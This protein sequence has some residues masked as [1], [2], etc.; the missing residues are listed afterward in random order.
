MELVVLVID[1][2]LASAAVLRIGII[3]VEYVVIGARLCPK[4]IGFGRMDMGIV[5]G[6]RRQHIVVVRGVGRLLADV[7]PAPVDRGHGSSA[8][9]AVDER[10]G[11]VLENLLL[12]TTK[13][14]RRLR[15]IFVFQGDHEDRLDRA[16]IV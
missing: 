10:G 3:V 13:L 16:L 6:G 12:A 1:E 7:D 5:P 9:Q 14:V 4:V 8:N 11:G 15:P 2:V